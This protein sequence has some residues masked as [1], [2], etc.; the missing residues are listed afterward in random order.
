MWR[1]RSKRCFVCC[2]APD[3][4]SSGCRITRRCGRRSKIAC[5]GAIGGRSASNA[6]AARGGGGRE[7]PGSHGE[8]VFPAHEEFLYREPILHAA[9]GGDAD[10]VYYAA[11][12]DLMRVFRRRGARLVTSSARLRLGWVGTVS[13]SRAARLHG[14]GVA[15]NRRYLTISRSSLKTKLSRPPLSKWSVISLT[16]GRDGSCGIEMAISR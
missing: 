1:W 12:I 7:M 2:D 16:G 13:P 9:A 14:H 4:S 6:A 15:R 8:S 3:T 11:P 10:A 5:A